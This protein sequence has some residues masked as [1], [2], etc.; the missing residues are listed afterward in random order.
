MMLTL[1]EA[2]VMLGSGIVVGGLLSIW[3]TRALGSV[4]FAT[5]YFDFVNVAIPAVLLIV[6]GVGAVLPPAWRAARTDP[7]ITLRG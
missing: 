6:V 3:A 2:A 7:L 5:S 1:R 4:V